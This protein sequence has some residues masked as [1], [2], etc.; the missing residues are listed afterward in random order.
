MRCMSSP[1]AVFQLPM[2]WLKALALLNIDSMLVTA[3]VSQLLMS[4][5][6]EVASLNMP[7]MLV[8][9][10]VFHLLMSWLKE[11]APWNMTRMS[12]TVSRVPVAD[13]LVEGSGVLEHDS[14]VV[15]E[16]CPSR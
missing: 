13:G 12:V 10:A 7:L 5:L 2:G 8:T 14:M 4:W 15:T 11:V 9:A 3:A 16:P 1:A 6:K